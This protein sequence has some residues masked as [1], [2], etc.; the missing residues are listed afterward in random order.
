MSVETLRTA[1]KADGEDVELFILFKSV[2]MLTQHQAKFLDIFIFCLLFRHD[3]LAERNM[4][5]LAGLF[6][7]FARETRRRQSIMPRI[8]KKVELCWWKY[9][10]TIGTL[11]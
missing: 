10:G 5:L 9:T 8:L 2:C 6:E 3:G 1:R 7:E 4:N 11:S